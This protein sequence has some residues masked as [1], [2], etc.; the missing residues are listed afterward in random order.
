MRS[1][2]DIEILLGQHFRAEAIRLSANIASFVE[3]AARHFFDLNSH[4]VDAIIS[5]IRDFF[6]LFF[7]YHMLY[8]SYDLITFTYSEI[9]ATRCP[10][11]RNPWIVG[12]KATLF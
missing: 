10:L 11:Q 4:Y 7:L 5:A 8:A 12:M 9:G 3:R 1:E 6:V 2:R